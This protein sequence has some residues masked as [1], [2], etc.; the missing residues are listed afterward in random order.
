M[1]SFLPAAAIIL[2]FATLAN[3][4]SSSNTEVSFARLPTTYYLQFILANSL[5]MGE[6]CSWSDES[7]RQSGLRQMR[8]FPRKS[9]PY[10][11]AFDA[12]VSSTVQ[13]GRTYCNATEMLVCDK[14]M[15]K[16][17]CG[18]HA[19]QTGSKVCRWSRGAAC[20]DREAST[21]GSF[22]P[23]CAQGLGCTYTKDGTP[24]TSTSPYQYL[25]ESLQNNATYAEYNEG[26]LTG[27]MC[28]CTKD[29]NAKADDTSNNWNRR[30]KRS[31][32]GDVYAQAEAALLSGGMELH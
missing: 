22:V 26:A 2:A 9:M 7:V 20:I 5:E 13:K 6:T 11:Q 31:L 15:E 28:Q 32:N 8:K 16:C 17:V 30:F 18:E 12:L 25:L 19:S 4:A 27:K 24:C 14:E 10:W 23:K 1:Q 29:D 3:G 21:D